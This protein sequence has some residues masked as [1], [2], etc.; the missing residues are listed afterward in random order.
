MGACIDLDHRTGVERVYR[1]FVEPVVGVSQRNHID[2]D[3]TIAL[4]IGVGHIL[5][6]RQARHWQDQR[7]HIL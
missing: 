5:H 1:V 6:D 4:V 7:Q 2:P 3:G